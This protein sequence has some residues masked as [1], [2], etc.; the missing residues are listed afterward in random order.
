MRNIQ[1]SILF[2]TSCFLQ[3]VVFAQDMQSN[4]EESRGFMYA[5]GKIYVVVA[6]VVTIVVGIFIYLVNLDRKIKK[7][8]KN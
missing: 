3:C 4:T 7:L 5:E 6:V 1:K 2:F 8:E